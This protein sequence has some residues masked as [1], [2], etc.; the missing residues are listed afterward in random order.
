MKK[1]LFLIINFF[2]FISLIKAETWFGSYEKITEM[3]VTFI[4]GEKLYSNSPFLFRM[5]D[6]KVVYCVKPFT[7]IGHNSP[8]IEYLY[9]DSKFNISDEQFE[10][11]KLIA[12]YG[13][14]YPGHEDRKWYGI[15]QYLIWK[16]FDLDD[17]YF[18]DVRYGNKIDVYEEEINEIE[19]LVNNHNVIPNID[20][21][22]EYKN[23]T[24]YIES[25]LNNVLSNYIIS[26][27]NIE[28]YISDNKLY[29]SAKEDGEY[30]IELKRKKYLN[31]SYILY[32]LDDYQTLF[33][34]GGVEDLEFKINIS[35]NTGSVTIIK[36]DSELGTLLSDAVYSITKDGVFIDNLVTDE[37]GIA[38]IE[39]LSLGEY[40][41]KE[42]IPSKGYL[43]DNNIYYANITKENKDVTINSYED[44]IKQNIIINKYYGENDNYFLEDNAMFEL[45]DKDNNL[46]KEYKTNKG[47]IEDNLKY[48]DYYL[49]Q[50]SGID[51]YKFIDDYYFSINNEALRINLYNHKIEDEILIVDVPNTGIKNSFYYSPLII[52]FGI[53]LIIISKK[54]TFQ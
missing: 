44:I 50:I 17:I 15:T 1:I 16:T 9:N 14:N 41:I 43:L 40:L 54:A 21:T 28:S 6:G 20:N 32:G 36:K 31:N 51:N 42:E 24:L 10:R 2:V 45:Y 53:V 4:K 8:Y 5:E 13:Y 49:K 34:P 19:Y 26:D 37:N 7:E 29:I 30:Y 23:N 48:G 39:D 18:T 22:L 52:L 35:V 27:S 46:I 38:R 12:Y 11:I 47:I 3:N 25:D 33:Y